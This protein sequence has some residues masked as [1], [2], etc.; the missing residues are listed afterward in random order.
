MDKASGRKID[1]LGKQAVML[2]DDGRFSV[3][4]VA[5]LLT[6]G[7]PRVYAIFEELP[8]ALD[9]L[10]MLDAITEGTEGLDGASDGRSQAD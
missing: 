9:A 7:E 5:D 10:R 8:D 6:E 4:N 3:V 1:V 2:R